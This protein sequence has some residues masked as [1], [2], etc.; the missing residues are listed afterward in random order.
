MRDAEK[1][2]SA[3]EMAEMPQVEQGEGSDLF[4]S[5]ARADGSKVSVILGTGE[6]VALAGDLIEAARIRMARADWPP[7]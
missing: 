5:L 4:L 1:P 3:R 7:K 2:P 6:A